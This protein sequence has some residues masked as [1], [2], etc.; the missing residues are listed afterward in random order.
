MTDSALN[1]RPGPSARDWL[2]SHA[3]GLLLAFILTCAATGLRV[4]EGVSMFSPLIIAMVLGAALRTLMGI[5][6]SAKPGLGFSQRKPLRAAIVLLGLQLTFTQ[7]ALI[8]WSGLAIAAAAL[9]ATFIFTLW[10]GRTMG[11]E[12]R[13]VALIAGGSAVCGAS[14]IVAFNTVAAADDEDVA[15]AVAAVTVFGSIAMLAY[16]L[17]P[18]WLALDPEAFGLWAGASIHEIAQVAGAAFQNGEVSG[19]TAL[20]AKLARVMMLAP[21]VLGF[22]WLLRRRTAGANDAAVAPPWFLAGFLVMVAVASLI[23]LP[24]AV[25]RT[26]AELTTFLMTMALA[27]MG[28]DTDLMKLKLKGLAPLALAAAAAVFITLFSLALVKLAG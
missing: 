17:T 9:L 20:V 2:R 13:L 24:D 1:P 23:D 26:V 3:P 14:A 22:A 7:M 28:L 8:G 6:L 25:V 12:R 16:P 19:Q 27:A 5:P 21:L 18:Q 10:L 11:I 4:I 15:Y